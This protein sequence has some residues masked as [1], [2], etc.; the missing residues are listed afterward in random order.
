[1]KK[2]CDQGFRGRLI[3]SAFALPCTIAAG[4]PAFA[5]DPH[6]TIAQYAHEVWTTKNGLPEA[7]VMAILQ[8]RDGYL[9]V[10]SEEGLARFDG[11]TFA[12]FDHRNSPLPNNRIQ[13]LLEAPDGSLWVGTENGL[14]R[15][16][17][18]QFSN[19]SV[20]D[21]LPSD[22]ISRPLGEYRRHC[23]GY[24]SSWRHR[25]P[26]EY[27]RTGSLAAAVRRQVSARCSTHELR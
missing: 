18:G 7:D 6:K 5:L 4:T 22:N 3:A 9:W 23:L 24:D 25:I 21:G 11:V 17:D 15:L 8:T 19:F 27:V 20:R 1:M 12:V 26:Q 2:S 16:K 10:G 13:A 14:A